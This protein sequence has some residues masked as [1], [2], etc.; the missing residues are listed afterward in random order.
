MASVLVV[1]DVMLDRYLFG[2]TS[3][4]SPEAPVPVVHVRQD[5]DRAG[6]AANVAVNLARLGVSTK[7][8][9][10]VGQDDEAVALESAL[11]SSGVE[12]SFTEVAGWP[13]ITKTRV[14]SRGQQLIRLDR[15]EAVPSGKHRAHKIPCRK[16]RVRKCRC[17][18]RLR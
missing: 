4:I 13:T 1:G 8:L 5:E 15:E 14:Q 9:G 11:T 17:T 6:G 7:L 10:I 3:R 12:C 16:P 2:G 18:F